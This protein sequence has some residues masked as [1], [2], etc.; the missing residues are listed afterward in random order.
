METGRPGDG[1]ARRREARRREARRRE[2]ERF[3]QHYALQIWPGQSAGYVLARG[4]SGNRGRQ[5]SVCVCVCV[6]F[7][8]LLIFF[9]FFLFL[10]LSSWVHRSTFG[11]TRLFPVILVWVFQLPAY[12]GLVECPLL[13]GST[14]DSSPGGLQARDQ[15]SSSSYCLSICL[16]VCLFL[17]KCLSVYASLFVE[18]KLTST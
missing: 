3:C 14:S 7:I 4:P 8:L 1:E 12:I 16:S 18:N 11:N 5:V 9:F 6:W 2:V 10:L 15:L 13:R 17:I